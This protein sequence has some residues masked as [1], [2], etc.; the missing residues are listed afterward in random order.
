MLALCETVSC[1]RAQLLRYFG[2]EAEFA[3]SG[4]C[5]TCLTPPRTWDATVA[6]QKLLSAL[7]RL[8]RE[9]GQKFGSGQVIDVLLGRENERSRQYWHEDLSVWGIGQALRSSDRMSTHMI[10]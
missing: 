6:A 1:R 5:D 10:Y 4:N 2:Q 7:I 3:T 9:R 8:D